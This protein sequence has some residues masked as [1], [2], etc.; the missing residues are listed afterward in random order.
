MDFS[1]LQISRIIIHEIF[2]RDSEKEIHQPSYGTELSLLNAAGIETLEERIINAIGSESNSMEMDIV[3]CN[4]DSCVKKVDELIGLE[5]EDFIKNS[6]SIAYK[7]AEAQI[8]R[9][10]PGGVVVIVQGTAGEEVRKNLICI[11]KAEVHTGFTRDNNV[12]EFLSELLLTPQQKLYKIAAF[13]ENDLNTDN[14]SEKY[15]LCVYDHNMKRAETKDAATYFYSTFLGS[16]FKRNS[17][18]IT[19][20]FYEN[21]RTIVNGLDIT[22]EEKV[23][24]NMNLYSYM[25]SSIN[26]TISIDEFANEYISERHRDYFIN[27]MTESGIPTNAISKDTAYINNRLKQRRIKFTNEVS[28]IAPSDKFGDS[29][30]IINDIEDLEDEEGDHTLILVKGKIKEQQ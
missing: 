14:L 16:S 9:R 8:S 23:D 17:K 12:L 25:K 7:L 3:N 11:I 22:D 2:K 6:R 13:I 15:E 29:I 24:I 4:I 26:A 18:I 21:A 19:R 30:K 27:E 1:N 20:D 5:D 10:I 28:I